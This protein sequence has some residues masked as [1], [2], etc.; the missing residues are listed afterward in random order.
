MSWWNW[1]ES[2]HD[3]STFF[4]VMRRS[5]M[6]HREMPFLRTIGKIAKAVMHITAFWAV[7][8]YQRA[9]V[10][11]KAIMAA[12]EVPLPWYELWMAVHAV[13]GTFAKT[14]PCGVY[15]EDTTQATFTAP[16]GEWLNATC[17]DIRK[18][19]VAYAFLRAG[20][21][22][23]SIDPQQSKG[24]VVEKSEENGTHSGR[25]VQAPCTPQ[26]GYVYECFVDTEVDGMIH[27][28]RVVVVRGK[29]TCV[30]EIER[31]AT[32]R[33]ADTHD[34]V[35]ERAVH[36]VFSQDEQQLILRTADELG[37]DIGD[38]DVL[39]DRTTEKIYIVD[40]NKTSVMP[41][42]ALSFKQR[43]SAARR[44]GEAL[45]GAC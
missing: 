18:S 39:R 14:A 25:L 8:L 5:F 9:R 22:P 24:V 45:F 23:I 34:M 42:L 3:M 43:L 12:P 30:W 10:G 38:F 4:D 6:T 32:L 1:L 13:G 31:P 21:A 40:A 7:G 15:F 11:R 44:I 29:I 35:R 2:A 19:T 17:T 16:K 36:D 37:M 27:D 33:F 20:G 28:F 26:K 41:P